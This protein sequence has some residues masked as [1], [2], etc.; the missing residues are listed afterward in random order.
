[1]PKFIIDNVIIEK[2]EKDIK[3]G[4][5]YAF[6]PELN[7]ICGRNEAG[8]SS[9][10]QF[11]KN[12]FFRP[13]K[14]DTGKIFFSLYSQTQKQDY[15][16][17]IK[18]S[19][20]KI[21][22]CKLYDSNN[23]LYDYSFIETLIN[24]KYYEQGFTIDIDDL[25][26]LQYDNN[27]SL[28]NVIKDPSGDKLNNF[29]G[30]VI[31]DIF[32]YVGINNK[33]K[34][35][36]TDILDK[37]SAL[38]KQI[39]ELSQKEDQYNKVI[40]NI[41]NFDEEITQL[42]SFEE[43]INTLISLKNLTDELE[44]FQKLYNQLLVEFNSN[45]YENRDSYIELIQKTGEYDTNYENINK[46]KQKLENITNKLSNNRVILEKEFNINPSDEE[47]LNFK[48]EYE[49]INKIK[50]LTTKKDDTLS[51]IKAYE[52]NIENIEQTILK[53]KNDFEYLHKSNAENVNSDELNQ[54]Y[55]VLDD[56][57]TQYKYL[58]SDINNMEKRIKTNSKSIL[59]NKNS[60]ILFGSLLVLTISSATV[61]FYQHVT[62]AGIFSV[63]LSIL[64]LIGFVI[65]R[66]GNTENISADYIM[67][68]QTQQEAILN[69]LI[70][71]LKPYYPEIINIESSYL[72]EK[73]E[74]LKQEVN[75][76]IFDY[77]SF[78]EKLLQNERDINF[79][80]SQ[81]NNIID[82]INTLN[83]EID[84]NNKE[85]YN[86][87]KADT[88][89]ITDDGKKYIEAVE[90]LR[91]IKDEISEKNIILTEIND[92]EKTNNN[93]SEV[94]NKFITENNINIPLS[95]DI[96]EN[97]KNLT[98][99]REKNNEVK[100]QLD[101]LNV[102]ING[103]QDKIK[104]IEET[105]KGSFD[106]F[107]NI[108]LNVPLTEKLEEIE[109]IKK[110]K[111]ALKKEAEFEKK[112]LEDIEGI[113]NLKT[114]RNILLNEYRNLIKS[115]YIN[116]T[117]IEITKT[118]KS[119]F[120]KTQ[121]DL[122]NAQKYLAMLTDG[123]YTKINLESE[124]I[125][126]ADT[127]NIKKWDELSRGTKE[128]LYLALRLGYASNYSKDKTT[129]KSNGRADLPLIIDDAFVN[130]DYTRTHN[131]IKCL[132]DF[133]KTNQILFFTCHTDVIKKHF[134]ELGYNEN[135]NLNIIYI[136]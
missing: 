24:Q 12:G 131:A 111:Q 5:K 59:S 23:K 3:T 71:K 127:A 123:K 89:K 16:A 82:K 39:N 28:I 102:S 106:N 114:E 61:S 29:S 4:V 10:M 103:I 93:I 37:I 6:S 91:T 40:F 83:E 76:K 96:K 54:L 34:K 81:K 18:N 90:L 63:F 36:L 17:D 67:R 41:H 50:E 31:S 2:S 53:L 120:D 129:L 73:I 134:E 15:R 101:I 7:L 25:N 21:E 112:Q 119:N 9:L 88:I 85:F 52:K 136:N 105:K 117:I 133:S 110:E 22:R 65:Q 64:I 99:Y 128:Q 55:K 43:Y 20:K 100:R 79:N 118:A 107:N 8:K 58:A 49:V 30:K 11:L 75:N 42:S 95:A 32:Q 14:I 122:I 33:P 19:S 77:K 13:P 48:I 84:N 1:M 51:E 104:K 62:T 113:C 130:F 116:K 68:K 56:G 108:D 97:T 74:K 60:L 27:F 45:L 121:P 124:E 92:T 126:S 125:I 78:Q 47:I 46:N 38:T 69:N 70:D 66:L 72:I 86:L 135:S 26:N 98:L 132:I 35:T 87:I 44:N 80:E 109:Q 94:F 115:I 57:L